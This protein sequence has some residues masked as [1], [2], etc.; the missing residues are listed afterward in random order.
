MNID[1][2]AA[3]MLLTLGGQTVLPATNP[4]GSNATAEEALAFQQAL[5]AQ[6]DSLQAAE[7]APVTATD[8]TSLPADAAAAFLTSSQAVTMAD[9][10]ILPPAMSTA[11]R[12]DID[13]AATLDRLQNVL[14][15]ISAARGEASDVSALTLTDAQRVELPEAIVAAS[16]DQ[17]EGWLDVAQEKTALGER[18]M[19]TAVESSDDENI[20]RAE[21]AEA[22]HLEVLEISSTAT[23]SVQ[24]AEI[25]A[26]R[27]AASQSDDS[28]IA[29]AP[30]AILI[31][32]NAQQDDRP[33]QGTIAKRRHAVRDLADEETDDRVM[34]AGL[35]PVVVPLP[36]E[37]PPIAALAGGVTDAA[38]VA[39]QTAGFATI[40]QNSP[41][42]P[43]SAD[44]A[45]VN[46]SAE[47]AT[48][49]EEELG[50]ARFA[51]TLASVAPS[52]LSGTAR[53]TNAAPAVAAAAEAVPVNLPAD[54]GEAREWSLLDRLLRRNADFLNDTMPVLREGVAEPGKASHEA[55]IGDKPVLFD[56]A[57]AQRLSA[58]NP[59]RW[60]EAAKAT[61]I[62]LPRPINDPQWADELGEKV[63]WLGQQSRTSAEIRLNPQSLGPISIKID[64]DQD[65][66]TI[67]F[68]AQHAVTREALEAALPKLREMLG[69]HNIQLADVNISQHGYPG[70]RAQS[71]FSQFS[72]QE[73]RA[74]YEGGE[75][76]ANMPAP[77]TEKLEDLEPARH[78][79]SQGL[80]SYYV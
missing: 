32:H 26:A 11:A 57:W 43:A 38:S 31:T 40:A 41:L 34:A 47:T 65:R 45:L 46:P 10:K 19:P 51:A 50:M 4:V 17:P 24:S 9:G 66:A 29:E 5:Q 6:Y 72:G 8:P 36:P 48:M 13:L 44:D 27:T 52:V 37:T 64:M 55:V 59:E 21:K 75:R 62:D 18:F 22:T 2:P 68:G 16:A 58:L 15:H 54:S 74:R 14:R 60:Q 63:L 23:A 70:E 67:A 12:S 3:S 56:T 30:S 49:Q 69:Q 79:L 35:P 61:T 7:N 28:L 33:D 25:A 71:G 39:E 53:P 20:L 78:L 42:P 77:A 76:A 80:V 1:T 73:Q